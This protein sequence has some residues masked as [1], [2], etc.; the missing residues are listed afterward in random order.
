MTGYGTRGLRRMAI[1]SATLL[2]VACASESLRK[3][4]VDMIIEG[5]YEEGL[6]KLEES[7]KTDPDNTQARPDRGRGR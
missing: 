5:H 2:L 3:Q 7:L 1:L 4:G 6:A